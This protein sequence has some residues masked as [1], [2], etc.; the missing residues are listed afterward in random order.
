MV[1]AGQVQWHYY[2]LALD[3]GSDLVE[4]GAEHKLLEADE[5]DVLG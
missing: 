4:L 3:G 2:L 1:Q 5:L